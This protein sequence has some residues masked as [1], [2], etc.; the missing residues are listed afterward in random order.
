M[1]ERIGLDQAAKTGKLSNKISV[2]RN[3]ENQDKCLLQVIY[4]L[5]G[6]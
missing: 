2:I 1:I 3:T 4:Q 5:S 6:T